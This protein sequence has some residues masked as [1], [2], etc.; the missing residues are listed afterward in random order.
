MGLTIEAF[1][2]EGGLSLSDFQSDAPE[3]VRVNEK[4]ANQLAATDAILTDTN[5]D[6]YRG[7]R[8]SLLSNTSRE[9]FIQRHQA[10]RDALW[11]D[12]EEGIYDLL[13]DNGVADETRL[14]VAQ[15]N[16]DTIRQSVTSLL[17]IMAEE[18]IAADSGGETSVSEQSRSLLIDSVRAVNESKRRAQAAI[19][20]YNMAHNSST[21]SK[22]VDFAEIMTPFAEWININQLLQASKGK[23]KDSAWLMGNQKAELYD[24]IK[25]MPIEDRAAFTSAVVEMVE[26]NENVVLPDGNDLV[27]LDVLHNMLVSNDYS[28]FERWF[29]NTTSVLEVVG[30]GS[31]V[32]AVGKAGKGIKGAAKG[33]SK[34]KPQGFPPGG[35]DGEI[36]EGGEVVVRDNAPDL[37]GPVIDGTFTEVEGINT[38]IVRTQVAPT[39]PSQVVKD[40]NPE[41]ARRM[42]KQAAEDETGEMAE[43]LYGT[44]R[45]EAMAKDLLPEPETP[46]GAIKNKV[47]MKQPSN[48]EPENIRKARLANG[49]TIVSDAEF[50]RIQSKLEDSFEDVEGMT[51]HKSSLV[52]R[53]NDDATIGIRARYSPNDSGIRTPTQAL[54]NAR[55]AF[56]NYGLQDENFTILARQGDE[57]VPTTAKD[58]EA[59]ATL[60]KAGADLP[61][62]DDVDYAIELNYDYRFRPE[63][64]EDIELLTTGGGIISRAVQF[65]DRTPT[66]LFASTGQGSIVQNLLD[67]ASVIH[68]QIVEAASVAVDRAY[69][70]KKLYVEE[71]EDFTD[72]Y[73]KLPKERRA[74]M[75]EYIN[76][77]NLE[78]IPLNISNLY[79]RGFTK[80]EVDALKTWRRA[81]DAMWHAANADMV[82]TLRAKGFKV[83]VHDATDTKL[84]GKPKARNNVQAN[85]L[86]F[87]PMED[88]N[89]RLSS[90]E[91]SELYEKGGEI[92]ELDEPIFVDGQWLQSIV[93]HNTPNGGYTRAV[94]DN[95]IVLP[96]RDGYYPVMY[97]ANYFVKKAVV[98]ADGN[99][100]Y[101]AV[102]SARNSGDADEMMRMLRENDPEAEYVAQKDRSFG[103]ATNRIFDEGSWSI[104][105]NSG[106]TA[107]R[108]R[109]QRLLDASTD[110]QK[111]GTS[112]LKD[113]LEAVAN[114]IQQLS[115]RTA[116]R[117]Y[118]ET[119]KRRWM[120]QFGDSLDL[121]INPRSHQIEMPKNVG[122]ITPK[123]GAD[124]KIVQEAR[125][126]F[127]YLY[128]LEN[129]FINYIDEA[130]RGM[131]HAAADFAAG[132]KATK[133]EEALLGAAR[134]STQNQIK[135][136]VFK[137]FIASNPARQA[138][139]Q[140]GQIL[141]LGASNPAYA[142]SQLP[143]DMFKLNMVRSGLSKDPK[144]VA[145]LK[146]VED[147]GVLEA[148]DAHTLIRDDLLRLA[149]VTATQKARGVLATPIDWAQKVGFDFAEQD[150]LLSAWL[151]FRDKAIKEGR[152]IKSQR[153]RDDILGKARAYTLNMNRSGEMPYSQNTLAVAAQFFSFRHKAFLQPFTNRSLKGREK[154]QMMAWTTAIFG[155]D[156]TVFVGLTN[157]LWGENPPSEVKDAI[158]DGLL[159]VALNAGLTAISG[160]D[161]MVDWGDFAPTDA[162]GMGNMLTAMLTTDL[163]E[164]VANSP[165][166]SLMFGANP[167][168]AD[169]F[170]TGMRYFYPPIDYEDPTLETK[171]SDVVK[172]SL[173]LF[174]GYSTTFRANYAY[175]TR[176]KMSSSGRLSDKD[177]TGIEAA[178][179]AFGFQTKTEVGYRETKEKLY[180]D[181]AFESDDVKEWYR[182]L[183]RHL[184]R[185]GDRVIEEDF[186][187]R[188]YAEAW[189]VF[190]EDR[191]RAMETI[192]SELEKDAADGDYVMLRS[193]MSRMGMMNDEEVWQ[194]INK[195]PAGDVRDKATAIMQ[196]REELADG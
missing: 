85:R 146:E 134:I 40:Y 12:A 49:N 114:Q 100:K 73:K 33:A 95:E 119:A 167:R 164:M 84:M 88:S 55:F 173:N 175:H 97:D 192:L 38:E 76:E 152:N 2:G 24:Q 39:S 93:S 90:E 149:D 67:A 10:I 183:K 120:L 81:N 52:I 147:S 11:V 87:D 111:A 77:A 35:L 63:D 162:Y 126:N 133:V 57:W 59:K 142:A 72:V 26:E 25:K 6:H 196:K 62:L 106:M 61:Q 161:Q 148:V 108:V 31:I 8:E 22:V 156:A 179:S 187:A 30:L 78:G 117:T 113:P 107:Q 180:G 181:A 46:S 34:A 182:G 135:S 109:G 138:L 53:T 32:R 141:Q 110:M 16:S 168:L 145:L 68:P 186:A 9:A 80:K 112:N 1:K 65:L 163:G 98:D 155:V 48:E 5:P 139:I 66:Q 56:R 44:N 4:T 82:K 37:E 21:A 169:A 14:G 105:T 69:G 171:F 27:A 42:H 144:Y 174:S 3:G 83:V 143:Q 189:R 193:L 118:L 91:L 13:A 177:V 104:A 172:S 140:R 190:G 23:D 60:K 157:W 86:T 116:M 18:A 20:A 94:Y 103:Q 102:A 70:L 125:T 129:G 43:A 64:L 50:G 130:Y 188:A 36:M 74:M 92:I 191:P 128:S 132:L 54:A 170:K 158:G 121:P 160:E 154:L 89:V 41:Q 79:A 150:V 28:D 184:A 165:A 159:D 115:Q 131:L 136:A 195:L 101:K 127:N 45:N 17:D 29:D 194:L 123:P 96:Y 176:Q 153:V 15:L 75:T 71:F 7:V 151:S 58:A 166:G 185:R 137:L 178:M 47:E 124:P 122:Q 19:N 99:T 51:L